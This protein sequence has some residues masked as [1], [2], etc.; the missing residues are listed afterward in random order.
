MTTTP[1]QFSTW[2]QDHLS[3]STDTHTVD[4]IPAPCGIG[5]S[6]SMTVMIAE[7]LKT[8]NGG[9]ILLITDEIQRMHNYVNVGEQDSCLAD[10]LNRNRSRILIYEA[11]NAKAD[12]DRLFDTPIIVMST[13]RF[14]SLSREA[15]IDLVATY[16]PKRHIFID[17]RAPLAETIKI[18]MGLFNDIDTALDTC[19]D[20]TSQNKEW[21]RTQ[22]GNL[23]NR[24]DTYMRAY[25]QSHTDYELQQWHTDDDKHATTDDA[26]FLRLVN[27]TYASKL[28]HADND[29]LK[30]IKAIFQLVHDGGLIISRLKQNSKSKEE[31][32]T[33]FLVTLDHSD[34][35]L[36]VGSKTVILDGTGNVDAVYDLWYVNHVP[37]DAFTR[38]L[39]KLTI[40]LVDVNTS[41]NAIAKTPESNKR[42]K[43]LIDYVKLFPKVDAVFTY[44]NNKHSQKKE[45]ET[46]EKLFREAGFTTGHFGGLKGTNRFRD[47]TDFVQIGLNRIP[48]EYYLAQALYNVNH[49]YPPNQEW[50]IA[51][52]V[53]G[54]AKR[55][56]LRSILTDLEQ[57]IFRGC[58]RN[59]DNEKPE[60]YTVVFACKPKLDKDGI[61]Y[62]DL[63]ELTTMIKERYEPMGATVNVLD[64]PSIF[65]KLKTEERQT[66]DGH[67]TA[68]Q[69]LTEYL[70]A[71][72]QRP[73]EPFK[74]ADIL[75]DCKITRDLY[76]SVLRKN[77]HIKKRLDGIK[78]DVQG[79]YMFPAAPHEDIA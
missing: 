58:I 27:E 26:K 66:S 68:A 19:L 43:A 37:C 50:A 30:K 53:H 56:M 40:N 62:N 20:N 59:A 35:L 61:D 48:E 3:Q 73:N 74:T 32:S 15:V 63:S 14:F 70:D 29:I 52:N 55:I 18:N 31:Y 16:I 8:I 21:L 75:R 12:R 1:G 23:R 9:G 11:A 42:L 4:L 64:T 25:E 6:Y 13:Q 39:S 51:V 22:W 46:V 45:N 41:K 33:F 78:T 24:Y 76:K 54:H 10:Y 72:E 2:L 71:R 44:G 7:T 77:R 60:T 79:W 5:K 67:K 47:F 36:D 49:R 28:R 69:K 57:N 65:E 34:L 38:D 17:E